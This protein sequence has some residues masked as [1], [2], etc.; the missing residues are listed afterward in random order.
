[1]QRC[2]IVFLVYFAIYGLNLEKPGGRIK[3][4]CGAD[5]TFL[6]QKHQKEGIK[7][8]YVK[9]IGIVLGIT[10]AGEGLYQVLPRQACMGCLSCWQPL[11]A[12]Q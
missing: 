1:M 8:K 6:R 12:G 5:P 3:A 11:W 4:M 7:M 10:M 9:Q 2:R